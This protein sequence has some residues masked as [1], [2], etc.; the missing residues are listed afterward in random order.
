MLRACIGGALVAMAV[1]MSPPGKEASQ[2]VYGGTEDCT[3]TGQRY[4]CEAKSGRICK[5]SLLEY[6]G[7]AEGARAD[8]LPTT[9]TSQRV[10]TD[11]A[12]ACARTLKQLAKGGCKPLN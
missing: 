1:W 4:D 3:G 6:V 7:V 8:A 12:G 2:V 11:N 9:D 5:L 10:C